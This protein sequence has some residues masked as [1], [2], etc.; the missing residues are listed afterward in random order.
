MFLKFRTYGAWVDIVGYG[1][2]YAASIRYCYKVKIALMKKV[3]SSILR[4]GVMAA[5]ALSVGLVSSCDKQ[6]AEMSVNMTTS[7]QGAVI[8][9]GQTLSFSFAVAEAS[10]EGLELEAK[11]DNPDYTVEVKAS[12]ATAGGMLYVTAPKYIFAPATVN[13][14]LTASEA[15]RTSEFKFAVE[16]RMVDTYV[17]YTAAANT[18]LLAPGAFAKLPAYKG[19]S[20]EK[21]SFASAELVW[22]DSKGMVEALAAEP[23]NS[24]F[25][26][27]L[28]KG[29][30]GN[31]VV[32]LKDSEGVIVWSYQL[33]V[34]S[35]DP[36]AKVMKYTYTPAEGESKSFEMMDRYLGALSSEA[37]KESSH[38]C[39]Y[40]W[41]RKDPF[42]TSTYEAK[43]KEVY[44]MKG[45]VVEKTVEPCAAE[46]NI[47]VSIANPFTHYSGV[48]GGNYGWLSN[49]KTFPK[50]DEVA[51]LWGGLS[52]TKGIYDPCPE[53][54][55]VAPIEAWYFYS[56]ASVVKEKVFADV[57][58]PANKDLL[59]RNVVIGEDKFWFPAQGE[60]QHNGNLSS[61]VG[62]TWPCAKAWS[63]TQDTANVRAWAA[64]VSPSSTSYK[65]GLTFGYEVPVRCVKVK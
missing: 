29:V 13:V 19:V 64:S 45:N 20:K 61:C 60:V 56:D 48:S 62:T 22:Q 35:Y 26:V 9:Q 63:G 53:G 32:A 36:S 59:G 15:S 34:S 41:G 10:M 8:Y 65:G 43:L 12:K 47:V 57:E 27:A 37:G 51:D 21:L 46:N 16:A 14:T 40:Q 18:F 52:G 25:W 4:L 3:A 7:T 2:V 44:D 23:S 1:V 17:E 38:G 28:A 24:A 49:T 31:A 30:S 33:W 5:L 55:M 42:P 11:C 50:T 39:F 58:T 54:W 6:A